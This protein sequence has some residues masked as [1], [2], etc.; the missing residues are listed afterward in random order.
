VDASPR[1]PLTL[2]HRGRERESLGTGN[3]HRGDSSGGGVHPTR[4]IPSG[5]TC[6]SQWSAPQPIRSRAVAWSGVRRE[7]TSRCVPTGAIC[8]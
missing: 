2:R 1:A 7:S 6:A 4:R 3:R 5:T 8:R